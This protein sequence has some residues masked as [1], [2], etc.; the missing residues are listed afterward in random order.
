MVV[1]CLV[2]RICQ[3]TVSSKKCLPE[4]GSRLLRRDSQGPPGCAWLPALEWGRAADRGAL[5]LLRVRGVHGEAVEQAPQG[6]SPGSRRPVTANTGLPVPRGRGHLCRPT[7]PS[8]THPLFLA[9]LALLSE[10]GQPG[11]E[12]GEA[13]ALA[14]LME[15]EARPAGLT[16][17]YPRPQT[18]TALSACLIRL[19]SW[20][21][22]TMGKFGLCPRK[23]SSQPRLST[24]LG[25][26]G[27]TA[28]GLGLLIHKKA[29]LIPR[30]ELNDY[31]HEAHG[32]ALPLKSTWPLWGAAPSPSQSRVSRHIHRAPRRVRARPPGEQRGL[33]PR[34]Q[35]GP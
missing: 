8:H 25:E 17:E 32:T 19:G 15:S 29:P 27:V 2:Q 30:A 18:R 13:K 14:A 10:S 3:R 35:V 34:A 1:K 26:D 12:A 7:N 20:G 28:L 16:G 11:R 31:D 23:V 24:P 21:T 33:S 9:F 6:P 22:G 5:R 4:V